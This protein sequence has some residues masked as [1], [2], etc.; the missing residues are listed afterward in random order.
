MFLLFADYETHKIIDI[1][2]SRQLRFLKH[3]FSRYNTTVREHVE[4]IYIDLYA[5]YMSINKDMF[6]NAGIMIDRFHIV[7][8]LTRAFNK[9]KVK[10]MASFPKQS[11]E[12]KR[13]KRY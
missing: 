8:L 12:Y 7:Q 4:N 2:E 3:Y 13:L 9:T 10:A 11:T 1:E 6:P 5:P